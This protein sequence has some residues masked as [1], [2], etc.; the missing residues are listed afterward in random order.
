[1]LAFPQVRLGVHHRQSVAVVILTRDLGVTEGL[2][3]SDGVPVREH[4]VLVELVIIVSEDAVLLQPVVEKP[5]I[6]LRVMPLS[7]RYS[8]MPLSTRRP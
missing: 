1:M 6:F 4:A 7:S 2:A 8:Y 3:G 5:F